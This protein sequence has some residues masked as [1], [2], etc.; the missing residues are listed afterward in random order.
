[1]GMQKPGFLFV[2]PWELSLPGGVN[3][4]VSNLVSE[5]VAHDRLR[6][7][8]LIMT[9]AHQ[10]LA[11][12]D[13]GTASM[14]RLRVRSP[15]PGLKRLVTFCVFLPATLHALHRMLRAHAV[16]TVNVHYPG[17]AALHWAILRWLGLFKGLLI[18]SFHGSDLRAVRAARGLPQ[19][20]WWLLLR[21]ADAIV[22]CSES[23]RGQVIDTVPAVAGKAVTIRN[24]LDVAR[25]LAERD[26]ETSPEQGEMP[27]RFILTIAAFEHKKGLDVL[28]RAFQEVLD[29]R[30]DVSLVV[31]GGS[32]PYR[33]TLEKLASDLGIGHRL[34]LLE[35]LP[36]GRVHAYLERALV[37]VLAS[38]EEPFGLVLL[39][40]GAYRLP[41][42]G[43]A[44]GGIPELITHGE[45]G[46]LVPAD[47]VAALSREIIRLL[48][49]SDERERLGHALAEHVSRNFSWSGAY[50]AYAALVHEQ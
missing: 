44:V 11:E 8:V 2:V 29:A 24:G 15:G 19:L 21:G 42:I 5:T 1:M 48:D 9:W 34:Q 25:F 23:L 40:A 33:N 31:I 38:R 14:L 20:W 3:Q 26:R 16:S 10:R 28:L 30:H 36:H 7:L 17:L 12:T 47:D 43:T 22:A 49:R 37:F 39:E 45:T 18:L 41:V 6:P 35:D 32:R 27:A 50:R 46:L 13:T 4:V